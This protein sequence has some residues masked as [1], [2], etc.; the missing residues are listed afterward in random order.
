MF[1]MRVRVRPCSARSSPRSV[2]RVTT[3]VPSSCATD[4]RVGTS[5]WSDPSGPATATRPGSTDTVTPAGISMGFLPIRL[6]YSP[7]EADDLAADPAL[8]RGPAR[9]EPGGRGQDCHAHPAQHARQTILPRIDPA[10][11]LGDALQA[12]DDPLAIPAEL[13][14]DDQGIEGFA[15]L[16][17]I[18]PDVALLLEEAGDLDLHPR[19]RHGGVLV[20][21]LVGVADAGEHVCDRVCQHVFSPTNWTWSCRESR[22]D[23]RARAGRSGRGRT[24]GRPRAAGR[25]GCSA[26][27][28][29][30]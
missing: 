6:M 11:R 13:E 26:C 9:D 21:R 30:P 7:D 2:G 5:C 12:R 25:T 15:L 18:V 4:I 24:C 23:A 17:V 28:S 20:Q 19:A 10:A 22:P 8:L 16:D 1:A 29:E 3:T 14:V 27:S